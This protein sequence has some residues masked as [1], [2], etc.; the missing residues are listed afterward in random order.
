MIYRSAIT[1]LEAAESYDLATIEQLK[2]YFGIPLVTDDP[3]D[4]R[5]HLLITMMSQVIADYCDRVFAH[6]KVLETIY[7]AETAGDMKEPIAVPLSR[8]PVTSIVG[9][10]CDTSNLTVG[11]GYVLDSDSGVLRGE[12]IG[13]NLSV[14]YEAGYDLPSAAPGP[15]SMAVIDMVRQSYFY[16]SRDP[17]IRMI[18]DNS[19]GSVSFF[20]P[21]GI[22]SGGRSGGSGGGGASTGSPLSPMAT[23]LVKPYRRPGMA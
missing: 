23:A 12:L 1:V 16:G 13:D 15:L 11:D 9:V 6:E 20:P 14:V 17:M 19:A 7:T 22:S 2:C 5:L 4:A 3:N 18:N 10:V 8:W 21:P